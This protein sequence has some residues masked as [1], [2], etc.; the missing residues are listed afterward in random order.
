MRNIS[1]RGASPSYA[2]RG[3]VMLLALIMLVSMTLAA[4]ALYRQMGTGLI[5]A[6]NLTFRRTAAVAADLG[7]EAA[8]TWL[9]TQP[10]A[11]YL[12][13]Q[14]ASS[15]FFYYAAWCYGPTLSSRESSGL[16]L[17]CANNL[18]SA[19]ADFNPITYDWTHSAVATTD[20]GAVQDRLNTRVYTQA[21]I[22]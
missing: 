8:R 7:V 1:F 13:N 5:I 20:D 11:T 10:L 19:A 15:K 14:Q 21:I 17:N 2:Q 12:A 6:R 4:V 22:Y 3:V 18:A 9:T 16:P